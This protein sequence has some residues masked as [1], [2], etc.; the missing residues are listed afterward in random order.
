MKRKKNNWGLFAVA[1]L[2]AVILWGFVVREDNP[3]V[4]INLGKITV[5]I[6]NEDVMYDNNLAY[7]ITNSIEVS[8]TVTVPQADGFKVSASDI[9][10]SADLSNWHPGFASIPIDVEIVNN[11]SLIKKYKLSETV[12]KIETETMEEK[13][14]DLSV[15][16]IGSPKEGYAVSESTLGLS[17]VTVKAPSSEM[18]RIVKAQVDV[19]I[20]GFVRSYSGQQAIVLYDGNNDIIDTEKE[21]VIL[22]ESKAEV[23]I[24]ILKEKELTLELPTITD[25]KKGYRCT[26]LTA[27][28]E[29]VKVLGQE[30]R[31]Q[32]IDSIDL[33]DEKINL[34]D[35]TGN[36]EKTYNLS[37]YLPKGI[38]I[39]S[40]ESTLVVVTANIQKLSEK[41]FVVK[42]SDIKL[43]NLPNGRTESFVDESAEIVVIGFD[44]DLAKITIEDLKPTINLKNCKLGEQEIEI[45][46]TLPNELELASLPK[47]KIS[48]EKES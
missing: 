24:T 36:V 5:E 12:L 34:K 45:G 40:D 4:D 41:V 10:L 35:E 42:A 29:S 32:G 9:K 23:S 21:Q 26:G 43:D 44:E 3:Q 13:E 7:D 15:N 27:S 20:D 46:V 25:C 47:I 30:R 16:V 22:S 6:L 2:L 14:L 1:F 33:S 18:K 48:V 39:A 11:N 28:V 31:L 37:D 19:D 8:V 38:K 17:K